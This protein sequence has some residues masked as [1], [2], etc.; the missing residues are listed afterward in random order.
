M[1]KYVKTAFDMHHSTV[2]LISF[3]YI[4]AKE[5]CSRGEFQEKPFEPR[6]QA[7]SAS[8]REA[9]VLDRTRRW[10]HDKK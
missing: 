2:V 8:A 5:K 10:E 6:S 7:N 1:H 4:Y 9:R 3:R